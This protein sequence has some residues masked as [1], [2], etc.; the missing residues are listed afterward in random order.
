MMSF[1]VQGSVVD[2]I[3]N[4]PFL[5]YTYILTCLGYSPSIHFSPPLN[6]TTTTSP[7]SYL[8]L[9]TCFSLPLLLGLLTALLFMWGM[10]PSYR[11]PFLLATGMN[12]FM[13]TLWMSLVSSALLPLVK[14]PSKGWF[15]EFLSHILLKLVIQSQCRY[16]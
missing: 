11:P 15:R 5:L 6:T 13:V 10:G 9:S 7:S 16:Q 3:S 4:A 14:R 1:R 2:W 8:S 12:S